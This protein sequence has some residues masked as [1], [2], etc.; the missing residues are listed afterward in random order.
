MIRSTPH[1]RPGF[2]FPVT[3]SHAFGRSM[4]AAHYKLDNLTTIIDNN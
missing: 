3:K 1:F 2:D 4:T